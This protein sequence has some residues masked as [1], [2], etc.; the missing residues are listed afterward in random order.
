MKTRVLITLTPELY[1]AARKLATADG[2][3]FNSWTVQ[4]IARAVGKGIN[5]EWKSAK[6]TTQPIDKDI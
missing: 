1:E 2:R 4:L 5:A 6:K 3:S